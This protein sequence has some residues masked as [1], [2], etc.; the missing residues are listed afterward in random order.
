MGSGIVKMFL[1]LM[2]VIIRNLEGQCYLV[3]G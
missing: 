2:R 1:L 3:V